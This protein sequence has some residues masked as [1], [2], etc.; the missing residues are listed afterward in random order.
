MRTLGCL[1]FQAPNAEMHTLCTLFLGS[2]Q[3]WALLFSH[4]TS[5][6]PSYRA[7]QSM[8]FGHFWWLLGTFSCPSLLDSLSGCSPTVGNFSYSKIFWPSVRVTAAGPL[9]NC[10]EARAPEHKASFR[11]APSAE[12]GARHT[13]PM[14][15][16]ATHQSKEQEQGREDQGG[17]CI[18]H[19]R[20]R[21]LLRLSEQM[22]PKEDIPRMFK[23]VPF[24]AGAAVYTRDQNASDIQ[25]DMLPRGQTLMAMSG[26]L[27]F[28]LFSML[29]SNPR[30]LLPKTAVPAYTT[31][32][33]FFFP[34]RLIAI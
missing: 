23:N 11:T 22:L 30:G 29:A 1:Q 19:H 33:T 18:G 5:S 14:L 6:E 24:P 21:P 32:S 10:A 7:S 2:Y 28:C 8:Y 27:A 13:L 3:H 31:W 34:Q 17:E 16:T 20:G 15:I 4:L 26:H 12:S 9:W 25:E